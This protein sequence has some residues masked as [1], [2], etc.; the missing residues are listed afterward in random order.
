MAH[1]F[2]AFAHENSPF[3]D[4]FCQQFQRIFCRVLF[5][6]VFFS[7][8]NNLF[9]RFLLNGKR[10]SAQNEQ[11][12]V[13]VL[14]SLGHL[15]RRRRSVCVFFFSLSSFTCS[16][17]PKRCF[18]YYVV[19]WLLHLCTAIP[20]Y[21]RIL[22]ANLC[23]CKLFSRQKHNTRNCNGAP[24]LLSLSPFARCISLARSLVRSV[25]FYWLIFC[26]ESVVLFI[27]QKKCISVQ[28]ACCKQFSC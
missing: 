17:C 4:L 22:N 19:H 1:G 10:E 20:L 3:V 8:L 21:M 15:F 13:N 5:P 16:R 9:P 7:I 28:V 26:R 2:S 24:L 23:M 27:C 11:S 6:L 12:L 18:V 25:T 14:I